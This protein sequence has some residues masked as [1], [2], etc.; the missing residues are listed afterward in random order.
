[1]RKSKYIIQ[2]E[3]EIREKFYFLFIRGFELIYW[4]EEGAMYQLCLQSPD[5]RINAVFGFRGYI[6][7]VGKRTAN[8]EFSDVF[9]GKPEWHDVHQLTHGFRQQQDL[10]DVP[11]EPGF[12]GSLPKLLEPVIDDVLNYVQNLP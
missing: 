11:R 12:Y 9:T 4:D 3:K 2:Y 5:L 1:M 7:G 10:E 6:M 8:F